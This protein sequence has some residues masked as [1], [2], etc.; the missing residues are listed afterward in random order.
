MITLVC[1]KCG[2]TLRVDDGFAG[3][4]CRCS[5][6]GTIQTVPARGQSTDAGGQAIF[7]RATRG[8]SKDLEALSEIV[9]SSG[10]V[11]S[12]MLRQSRKS[13]AVQLQEIEE[14]RKFA[15]IAI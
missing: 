15:P 11:G 6:C 10:L 8:T 2:N 4:V 9:T 1:T 13:S 12:G 14:R 7:E 3:G 5:A